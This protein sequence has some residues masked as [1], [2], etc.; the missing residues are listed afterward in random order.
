MILF[1]MRLPNHHYPIME[2]FVYQGILFT[3]GRTRGF[4]KLKAPTIKN[5]CDFRTDFL[6]YAENH[7]IVAWFK[8]AY[9]GEEEIK[10]PFDY[11]KDAVRQLQRKSKGGH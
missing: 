11:N 8:R 4:V 3:P 1:V 10:T 7:A 2:V 9:G 5:Q 6:L